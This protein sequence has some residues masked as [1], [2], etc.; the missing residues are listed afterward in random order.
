MSDSAVTVIRDD[1]DVFEREPLEPFFRE[2]ADGKSQ[3]SE[4]LF[5]YETVADALQEQTETTED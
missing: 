2:Q 4:R 3:V 5:G 1:P